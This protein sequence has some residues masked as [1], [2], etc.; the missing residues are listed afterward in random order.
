MCTDSYT[1]SEVNLLIEVLTVNFGAD[2][3]IHTKKG[4]KGAVYK[5]IYIKKNSFDAIKPKIRHH[6]YKSFHYKID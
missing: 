6:L 1:E 3:S 5:R 4:I 2:C